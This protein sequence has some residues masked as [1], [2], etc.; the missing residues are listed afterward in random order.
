MESNRSRFESGGTGKKK[1]LPQIVMGKG[2]LTE[3]SD[4]CFDYFFKNGVR[5]SIGTGKIVVEFFS[6]ATS[7]KV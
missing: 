6:V 2:L 5:R 1:T 4:E 3:K 7:V